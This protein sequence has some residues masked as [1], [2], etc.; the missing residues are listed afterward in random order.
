MARNKNSELPQFRPVHTSGDRI[1]NL[2]W[3]VLAACISAVLLAIASY[4][5]GL[6]SP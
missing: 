3:T 2:C 5:V 1:R 4:I 6:P